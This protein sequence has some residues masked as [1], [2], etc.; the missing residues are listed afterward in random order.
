MGA[1]CRYAEEL[2][3][4]NPIVDGKVLEDFAPANDDRT[5]AFHA[6]TL[7]NH[8]LSLEDK[9]KRSVTPGYVRLSVGL[10][11]S[12]DLI[13]DLTQALANA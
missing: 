9:F 8:K 11:H 3:Y 7:P 1:V 2:W 5:R 13:A 4:R 6:E 10:E 12:D